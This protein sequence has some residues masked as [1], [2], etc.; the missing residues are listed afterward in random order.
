MRNHYLWAWKMKITAFILAIFISFLAVK[1]GVDMVCSIL[2]GGEI[3]YCYTTCTSD[4]DTTKN[5]KQDNDCSSKTCNPFQV[6]NSCALLVNKV[7]SIDILF[8][9]NLPLKSRFSNQSAH[10]YQYISDFWHP[11]KVV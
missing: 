2:T 10:T 3:N 1:P 11:P 5:Q 7:A 4:S 9:P 6:C 8:K